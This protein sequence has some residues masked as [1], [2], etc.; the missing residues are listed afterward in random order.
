MLFTGGFSIQV[1]RMK[2][3]N[4]QHNGVGCQQCAS[5]CPVDALNIQDNGIFLD[6][7]KCIGCGLCFSD[8]PTGVFH[9]SQWDETT[10]S[11]EV[12][13]QSTAIT[14]FF[15]EYND[16]PF[17][18]KED[19]EKGAIQI[20][21]C[22]SSISKGAWYE[23]GIQTNVELRME[24]CGQCPM[25]SCIERMQY[26]IET[27]MEWLTA[28]G[29]KPSF[30][31]LDH[32][33]NVHKK[34][35]L[36]A[37]TTGMKVTSRRDLFLSLFGQGKEIVQEKIRQKD[38]RTHGKRKKTLKT[39]PDWQRRLES[40]Y[41]SNFQ[42]G[43]S[44]AYW[45]SIEKSNTCV[46]CGMCSINCP[47]GALQ[48]RLVEGKAVHV[49]TAGHCL[50]CRLCML[51]CPTESIQRDRKPNLHPFET[52]IVLENSAIECRK[53]GNHTFN[54]ANNLCYFCENE[55]EESAMI[56]DVLK[57]LVGSL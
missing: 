54:Q 13:K 39:L 24:K 36:K 8:C 56:S 14:Q 26:S 18:G 4:Y 52:E 7:E 27:A 25:N 45:P 55:A 44:A 17:L 31:Y 11:Q 37:V 2:C 43:G 42:E 57:H 35:R 10:L 33:N 41:T 49:F 47:T 5:H 28:S 50:D 51:F 19:K 38:Y 30:I 32:V 23:I 48:I 22:L 9:S 34:K 6:K 20:P 3:L 53:C 12:K 16:E 40:S 21:T 29:H 46:N 1:D 15:C